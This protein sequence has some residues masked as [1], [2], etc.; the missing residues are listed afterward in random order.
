[1][2]GLL[3]ALQAAAFVALLARLLPAR[4]RRA[5]E[6]PRP[7]ASASD[8]DVS[9]IVPTLDEARRIG[10]CLDG[11]RAQ[12]GV[13]REILVVDSGSRD[14][15]ADVVRAAA[16][17][18]PRIVLL[19]D[20]PLPEGWIGKP[21]A[22]QHGLANARGE[23]VLGMDAD[24]APNPGCVGGVLDAARA[25][26]YDAVSFAPRF[27]I[28]A[29]LERWLQ[30]ALLAT[31]VYRFGA[32]GAD[33]DPERVMANGQ[34]F[35]A[36]RDLLERTGG[37]ECARASFADDVTLAR[38]LARAGARVGFLDGS[39]LYDVR[40]YASA[41]EMWRE[42]GRSLDLK[43]ATTRSR[44]WVDVA[45]LA[46]AQGSPLVVLV[47][48][49]LARLLGTHLGTSA[50]AATST[51][52]ALLAVRVPLLFAL[53]G[54]YAC[55]GAPFWLSP[56]ADPLAALRIVLSTL[57]RPTRWRTREYRS[58]QRA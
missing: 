19:R 41:R 2:L 30:P 10:P 49:A 11:L 37:Y 46:V 5:P 34:C 39:R 14:G 8:G 12:G 25:R 1:V 29:P 43:D 26:G 3:A 47:A 35:L 32:A 36:R 40:A 33:A 27:V 38:S 21:W 7:A 24:T 53:A 28:D 15:T 16:A 57:R 50:I 56:L 23:W 17:L 42:W 9:V 55:R 54:S 18:D 44:Q 51:S 52:A 45:F 6:P 4:R 58:A 31:L 20:P 13:V 22:L 48:L